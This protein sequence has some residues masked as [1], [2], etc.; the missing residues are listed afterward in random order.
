MKGTAEKVLAECSMDTYPE[1]A[2]SYI[3]DMAEKGFIVYAYAMKILHQDSW[4]GVDYH[5]IVSSG[6]FHFLGFIIINQ[7]RSPENLKAIQDLREA[8]VKLV[9]V[10]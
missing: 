3:V 5:E 7:V 4:E 6:H 10:S 2:H 9:F 8:D 1:S